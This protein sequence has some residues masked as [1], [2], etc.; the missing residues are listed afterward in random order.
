MR[1]IERNLKPERIRLETA[2]DPEGDSEWLV[3]HADVRG[4]VD[5][6]LQRYADCKK[7]WIGLAPPSK[8]ALVR[9]L[10]NIH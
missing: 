7:E 6:V 8:R 4:S 5:K 1:L 3:I 2:S 10:Y 9:F